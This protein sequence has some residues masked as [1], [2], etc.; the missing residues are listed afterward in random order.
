MSGSEEPT[1]WKP[2]DTLTFRAEPDPLPVGD[3]DTVLI[4]G[5]EV[6]PVTVTVHE[7][8]T[9]EMRGRQA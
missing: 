6:I 1:S 7:D 8:G 4:N 9:V 3:H 5:D 2:G